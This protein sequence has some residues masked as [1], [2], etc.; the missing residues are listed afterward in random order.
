[1]GMEY[2]NGQMVPVTKAIGKITKLMVK[3]NF[4]MLMVIF[5]KVI[6]KMIKL[7]DMVF[8]SI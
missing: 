2:K 1:M 8:I 5:L 7:M 6:G 3:E 4:G